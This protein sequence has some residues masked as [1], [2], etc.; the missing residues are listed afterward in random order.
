M[1]WKTYRD[2]WILFDC[3]VSPCLRT[4]T[5]QPLPS[6]QSKVTRYHVYIY[7]V[8]KI[9]QEW[10]HHHL[11]TWVKGEVSLVTSMCARNQNLQCTFIQYE[12]L[13]LG[14]LWGSGTY[15][16]EC[17]VWCLFCDPKFNQLTLWW[18]D[19]WHSIKK[20]D[21]YICYWLWGEKPGKRAFF[22][23]ISLWCGVW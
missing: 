17:K 6:M 1:C 22:D 8:L 21:S 2:P 15:A 23:E 9:G 16:L 3:W 10:I 5:T 11:L 12:L 14:A 4:Y 19:V 7:K 18:H 20:G 13:W